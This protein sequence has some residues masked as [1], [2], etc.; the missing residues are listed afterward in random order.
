MKQLLW[1]NSL[2]GLVETGIDSRSFFIV[3]IIFEL[4]VRFTAFHNSQFHRA[5]SESLSHLHSHFS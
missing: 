3:P 4:L 1:I 5:R 2:N